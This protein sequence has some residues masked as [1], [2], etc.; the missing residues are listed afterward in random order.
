MTAGPRQVTMIRSSF[1]RYDQ[2]INNLTPAVALEHESDVIIQN[3]GSQKLAK[4]EPKCHQSNCHWTQISFPF[5]SPE[6][7]WFFQLQYNFVLL[8]KRKIVH[9]TVYVTNLILSGPT[10]IFVTFKLSFKFVC[11]TNLSE[12]NCKTVDFR[13]KSH[14]CKDLIGG[15]MFSISIQFCPIVL[16]K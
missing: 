1:A 9:V 10:L 14:G 8:K 12:V 13:I 11:K 4:S 5:F 2:R 6:W 3:R 7:N 15:K 16:P